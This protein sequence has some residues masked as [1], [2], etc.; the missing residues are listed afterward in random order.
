MTARVIEN[1]QRDLNIAQMNELA[2][3]FCRM[4]LDTKAALEGA[5]ARWNFH[6]YTPRWGT[7]HSRGPLLPGV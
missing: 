5:A 7:L 3:I 2:I 4:N 1:I 6:R